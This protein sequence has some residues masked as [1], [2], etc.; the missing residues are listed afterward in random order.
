MVGELR[1]A[2]VSDEILLNIGNVQ[3]RDFLAAL[4]D[5]LP[6]RHE[7]VLAGGVADD[8]ENHV[9]RLEALHELKCI[10]RRQ[11]IR[12]T[13][14]TVLLEQEL[15][16]RRMVRPRRATDAGIA[17]IQRIAHEGIADPRH[18]LEVERREWNTET[19]NALAD[20]RL[21]RIDG[22]AVAVRAVDVVDQLLNRFRAPPIDVAREW[23]TEQQAQILH[24]IT[25]HGEQRLEQQVL[26]EVVSPDIDHERDVRPNRRNVREVL[27]GPDPDVGTALNL[28]SAHAVKHVQV[29]RLVRDE[30]V[31]GEVTAGLRQPLHQLCE[32][33]IDSRRS[34]Y[35]R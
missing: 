11:I 22:V 26:E 3:R 35:E 14:R 15:P 12:L 5:E 8:G 6:D 32:R 28:Q 16:I 4:G 9:A 21:H 17:Q 31:G 18:R 34:W 7:G 13:T 27:V 2:A 1:K 30:I 29:R 23:L 19:A 33:G 24:S 10:L 25:R 20:G